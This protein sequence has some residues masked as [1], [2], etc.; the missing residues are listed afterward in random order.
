MSAENNASYIAAK[1]PEAVFGILLELQILS[2]TSRPIRPETH[3]LRAQRK[4]PSMRLALLVHPRHY[5]LPHWHRYVVSSQVQYLRDSCVR[6]VSIF[7]PASDSDQVSAGRCQVQLLQVMV[8]QSPPPKRIK[9]ESSPSPFIDADVYKP[10]VPP[11]EDDLGEDHCTICLQPLSDRTVLP[12][13][14]HEF[15]FDCIL[16]W[17]GSCQYAFCICGVFQR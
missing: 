12:A 10:E 1:S 11:L 3:I 15:C 6:F 13:C 7:C 17:T 4:R 16:M 5:L 14:S 9:L 2:R 8:S